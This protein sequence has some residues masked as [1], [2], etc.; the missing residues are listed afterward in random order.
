MTTPLI[1]FAAAPVYTRAEL[2]RAMRSDCGRAHPIVSVGP[3]CHPRMPMNAQ[4]DR[5]GGKIIL[6]CS[7]CGAAT[8]II[9]VAWA[10]PS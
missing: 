8:A 6:S 1:P 9:Q 7:V 3:R 5:A 4:Y 2:D 10:V